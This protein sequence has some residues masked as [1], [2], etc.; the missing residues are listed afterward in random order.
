[1][2]RF[3]RST[4]LLSLTGIFLVGAV[5]GGV[6]ALGLVRTKT[7][8]HLKMENLEASIM[9]WA[10]TRLT[11]TPDQVVRIQPL[12]DLACAEYRAEQGKTMGRVIEIIRA[13]NRRVSAE[14]TPA[15]VERLEKLE[16]E[17]EDYL[18]RKF[19]VEIPPR[20]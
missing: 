8:K 19:K 17:H 18:H 20:P 15:Q 11:L 16:R 10:K 9:E 7:E 6:T 3:S 4:I 2:N 5:T 13:S 1:M 12:V 14:L